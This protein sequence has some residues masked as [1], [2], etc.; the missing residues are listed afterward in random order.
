M[1]GGA[2]AVDDGRARKPA[3][4]RAARRLDESVGS[5]TAAAL[6]RMHDELPWFRA[7][8][9][10]ERSW[11]GLTAAAG[12]SSFVEWFRNPTPDPAV[13]A[14]VFGA[15]PRELT[16]VVTLQQTVE[17]VRTTIAVTEAHVEEL[18]GAGDSQ[19]VREAVMLFS[20][21]IAFA[22]A[23]IYAQ[24]AEQRGAWDARLEALIVDS[25]LRGE[26]GEDVR[27][28]ATALGWASTSGVCVVLGFTPEGNS[29]T[30]VDSI[31]RSA[32]AGRLD[33]LCAVQ[34]DRLVVVLGGVRDADHA[35]AKIAP[36]FGPGALVT[37][38]VVDDLLK[39]FVSAR[40]AIAGLRAAIAWPEA[41]RP[42]S[43]DDLLPERSLSGDGHARRQLVSDVYQPLVDAGSGLLETL[44]A[45]LDSSGSIEATGRALFV[46]PNTVR[47]RLHRIADVTGL[48]ANA[49]RDAYTLRVALTLGRLLGPV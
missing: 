6:D 22:A 43:S 39:A 21:E 38:P 13:T 17:M 8:S 20:R 3:R 47:Y 28:R 35:A 15:A 40:A 11:I 27:S 24:A 33:A 7:L 34:G 44:T 10:Q 32:H 49:A 16:G 19:A 31:K 26:A 1:T 18:V 30:V 42:V 46:H 29:A 5:L 37:G 2:T 25:V 45:Y 36:H 12:I 14:D 41:P 4:A 23:A 48:S 9:P